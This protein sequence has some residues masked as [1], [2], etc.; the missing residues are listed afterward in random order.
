[1][2]RTERSATPITGAQG[3]ALNAAYRVYV[4]AWRFS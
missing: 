4:S 1:M 3:A 2:S